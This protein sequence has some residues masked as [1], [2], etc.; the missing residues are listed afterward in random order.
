MR[1][2]WVKKKADKRGPWVGATDNST[3]VPES[4]TIPN[5]G[6]AFLLHRSCSI[7]K[8]IVGAGGGTNPRPA[9]VKAPTSASL[10]Q[11]ET[12]Q[13]SFTVLVDQYASWPAGFETRA[14]ENDKLIPGFGKHSKTIVCAFLKDVAG[15]RAA[16]EKAPTSAILNEVTGTACDLRYASTSTQACD[17]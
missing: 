14:G 8:D 16:G 7:L 15:A 11:Q 12:L 17:A 1:R 2:P 9:S 13:A 5:G 6:S 4:G 3:K 10:T